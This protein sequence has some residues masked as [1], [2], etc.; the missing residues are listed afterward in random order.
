MPDFD[1]RRPQKPI[2]PSKQRAPSQPS[3]S[4]LSAVDLSK[5]ELGLL[6]SVN[7]RA[8]VQPRPSDGWAADQPAIFTSYLVLSENCSSALSGLVTTCPVVVV[9]STTT[10]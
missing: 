7:G 10:V 3:K 9:P 8:G 5:Q 6:I 4:F 1:T 2:Q